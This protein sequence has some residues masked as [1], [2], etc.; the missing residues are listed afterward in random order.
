MASPSELEDVHAASDAAFDESGAKRT[1]QGFAAKLV[2]AVALAFSAYQLILAG[3]APLSSLPARSIHVAFLL[4]LS[5][6]IHPVSKRADRHRIAPYDAAL[7]ALGF[8]LGF[9]HL[10]FE[11]EL[12]QRSGDPNVMDLAVG[13]IFIVLVFEAARRVLG[14]ALPIICASFLA[15]GM[16]GQFLPG[17]LAHRGYGFDQI[18][19]QLFLGDRGHLRHPGAGL[20]DL[21]L[22]LHPL[23]QLP[24]ARRA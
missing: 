21:H 12:I 20:G 22:S 19:N 4:A 23:R 18:V 1:L 24:R 16:F 6:L 9:Y 14:L 15:Y 10:F 11:A 7:A 8:G 2:A 13:T 3:F 5:F 17:A